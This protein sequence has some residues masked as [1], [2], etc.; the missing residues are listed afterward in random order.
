MPRV[1]TTQT[2]EV[3][4]SPSVVRKVQQEL[5]VYSQLLAQRAALEEKINALKGRAELAF[6]DAGEEAALDAGVAIDTEDGPVKLKIVGGMT[7]PKLDET[8]LM[9]KFKLSP[10]QLDSCRTPG[11]PKKKYLRIDLPRDTHAGPGDE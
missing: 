10:K 11:K 3:A 8:K 2:V 4:V 5:A 6:L 1:T 9:K 7:A